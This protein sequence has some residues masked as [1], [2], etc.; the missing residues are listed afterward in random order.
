MSQAWAGPRL[1]PSSLG[2]WAGSGE[3]GSIM[4]P[5][6]QDGR[7]PVCPRCLGC[8]PGREFESQPWVFQSCPQDPR[9]VSEL[10]RVQ[11]LT[12]TREEMVQIRDAPRDRRARPRPHLDGT[13]S[14]WCEWPRPPGACS[15]PR[16]PRRQMPPCP[17]R[18][19]RHTIKRRSATPTRALLH[20][21]PEGVTPGPRGNCPP[22]TG[23]LPPGASPTPRWVFPPPRRRRHDGVQKGP[24]SVQVCLATPGQATAGQA[25]PDQATAG[26]AT[27]HQAGPGQACFSLA[28]T[29]PGALRSFFL[30]AGYVN[31]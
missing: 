15:P 19:E 20:V 21:Q 23:P 28:R 25:G 10:L 31:H 2:L 11:L 13:F 3:P 6:D 22:R 27:A 14:S 17:L 24:S 16:G 26:Q 12:D 8:F 7:T 5:L 18:R 1:D 29:A 9:K 30:S 4:R